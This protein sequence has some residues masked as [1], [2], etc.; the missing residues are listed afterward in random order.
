MSLCYFNSLP[1]IEFSNL[2][3]V[4]AL[5]NSPFSSKTSSSVKYSYLPRF[6]DDKAEILAV[7]LS[8][9]Y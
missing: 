2:L 8:K 7:C 3:I 1:N 6:S 4:G 5:S 9:F